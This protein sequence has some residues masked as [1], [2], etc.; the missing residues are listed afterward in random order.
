MVDQPVTSAEEARD[1]AISL[2]RERAYK[3]ITGN[4]Q[5]I[6]LPDLRPGTNVELKGLGKRFSGDYHVLKVE[7]SLGNTGFQTKFEAA[8]FVRRRDHQIIM[9]QKSRLTD[10]RFY[11]VE[12]GVV[13]S[14]DQDLSKDGASWSSSSAATT[15]W[16]LNVACAMV[17]RATTMASFRP[18]GRRR[19]VGGIHSR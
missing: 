14:V 7:H 4:G 15:R 10:N 2:L 1:L 5:V 17:R 11:G 8:Q 18:T 13:T 12:E 6:G 16:K 3:F 19:S 9:I